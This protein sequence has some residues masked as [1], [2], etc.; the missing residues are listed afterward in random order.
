MNATAPVP[1]KP[2]QQMTVGAKEEWLTL[3]EY[4][5]KWVPS[6]YDKQVQELHA[7]LADVYVRGEELRRLLVEAKNSLVLSESEKH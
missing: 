3:E 1:K 5:A 6:K 2:I 7:M 4:Y